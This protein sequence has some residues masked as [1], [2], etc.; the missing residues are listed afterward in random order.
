MTETEEAVAR[1]YE[2]GT[3]I[4]LAVALLLTAVGGYLAGDLSLDSELKRL[5]PPSAESVQGL[6]RLEETYGRQ[7]GRLAI[8]VEGPE[9][10]VNKG[11]VDQ[12]AEML[13]EHELVREVEAKRPVGFFKD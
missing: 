9:P 10:E 11:A 8:V 2:R 5:L 6:E 3:P 1:F 7:I 12:L 13:R 4:I